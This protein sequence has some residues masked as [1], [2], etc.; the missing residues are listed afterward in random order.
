MLTV[1]GWYAA[2]GEGG[3]GLEDWGDELLIS[4]VIIRGDII[5]N[6]IEN[7]DIRSHNYGAG[8]LFHYFTT[9]TEKANPVHRRWLLPW[10]TL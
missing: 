7:I 5:Q 3:G 9:L 2:L 4:R 8:R 6:C 1:D 10:S